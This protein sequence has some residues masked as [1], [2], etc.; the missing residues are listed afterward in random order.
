MGKQEGA[1]AP[2]SALGPADHSRVPYL[3]LEWGME[4][5][6]LATA[7]AQLMQEASRPPLPQSCPHLLTSLGVLRQPQ[8]AAPPHPRPVRCH[9][10]GSTQPGKPGGSTCPLSGFKVRTH[11]FL[12]LS[13]G[14]SDV[15]MDN[16]QRLS[17]RELLCC[18]IQAAPHGLVDQTEFGVTLDIAKASD[19]Q[20]GSAVLSGTAGR[21]AMGSNAPGQAS[22]APRAWHP[23]LGG[24]LLTMC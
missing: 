23:Q 18:G 22:L 8:H 5:T 10:C 12:E 7:P 16:D 9:S 15:L 21:G 1:T 11:L 2:T 13:K 6:E 14:Q 4:Y 17:V 3:D 19:R 20:R 24:R